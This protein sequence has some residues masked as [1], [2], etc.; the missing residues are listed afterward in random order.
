MD[1]SFCL[2][3]GWDAD[4]IRIQRSKWIHQFSIWQFKDTI[5]THSNTRTYLF[6]SFFGVVLEKDR[7]LRHL[8][9]SHADLSKYLRNKLKNDKMERF[10]Y[11]GI[12]KGS[13]AN[14]ICMGL[15]KKMMKLFFSAYTY[16]Y[17]KHVGWIQNHLW[18][19]TYP[20]RLVIHDSEE[21]VKYIHLHLKEDF[22]VFYV[23]SL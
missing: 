5:L 19:Q 8:R 18:S 13:S 4:Q 15:V 14:S 16:L 11:C 22:E 2:C 7:N 21:L 17:G 20:F 10:R 9:R 12:W 1:K 3:H 6:R 23:T